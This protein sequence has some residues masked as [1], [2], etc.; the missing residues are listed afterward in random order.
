M[1]SACSIGDRSKKKTQ[2]ETTAEPREDADRS[3]NEKR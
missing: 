2:R 1:S 3:A